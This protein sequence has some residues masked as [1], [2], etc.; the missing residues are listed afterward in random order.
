MEDI[1]KDKN[2]VKFLG[3]VFESKPFW[4][5]MA[6]ALG[7][8]VLLAGLTIFG[9]NIS[10]YGVMVGLGFLVALALAGQLFVLKKLPA[11]YPYTIIWWI[12]PFS[13]IGAR[14]YFLIFDGSLDSFL[15]I[16]RIWDGGLAIYGGVIGGFIGLI[17]SSLVHKKDIFATTDAVAPLLAIGQSFGRIGCI[18]GKCCY[19]VDVANKS[20]H[21][22]PISL[23]VAG[24]YHYATNFYESIL[25]LLLFIVLVKTL[26]KYKSKGINTCIYLIG[27]GF[28]RF[29]LEFF[30]DPRQ[31]LYIGGL[32]VSQLLSLILVF[33]GI[34]GIVALNFVN[35]KKTSEKDA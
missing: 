4:L 1:K 24:G 23:K 15:Q 7:V 18:F 29:I 22:F 11:D 32:P 30:R 35:N 31:T 33:V 26:R 10:W 34:I 5:T 16:F 27:Y 6:I 12:F 20:L 14:I 21:F 2:Q 13:I 8:I 9:V 3:F 28:I 19:G 17:I 25:D